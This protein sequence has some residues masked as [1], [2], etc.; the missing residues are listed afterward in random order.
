ML[1]ILITGW[2][3]CTGPLWNVWHTFIPHFRDCIKSFSLCVISYISCNLTCLIKLNLDSAVVTG[4]KWPLEQLIWRELIDD[5]LQWKNISELIETKWIRNN[6]V[7]D[8]P[9]FLQRYGYDLIF[10]SFIRVVQVV[11]NLT[12]ATNEVNFSSKTNS[13]GKFRLD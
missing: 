9:N 12:K 3:E 7:E 8:F 2:Y 11:S 10:L 6:G 4:D 1:E 5:I 13:N